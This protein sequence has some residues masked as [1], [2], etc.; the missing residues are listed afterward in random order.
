MGNT[1]FVMSCLQ[2]LR[3]PS[4]FEDNGDMIIIKGKFVLKR[5]LQVELSAR[6]I[7]N[8]E[9]ANMDGCVVLWVIARPSR[10]TVQDFVDGF[11]KYILGKLKECTVHL[12]FDR[13]IDYSTKSKTRSF[14]AGQKIRRCHT[15]TLS[16]P[17]HPQQVVLNLTVNR[18]QVIKMIFRQL[19]QW[20]SK[21]SHQIPQVFAIFC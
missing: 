1:S 20:F 17:F 21:F 11:L 9:M 6:V 8:P 5:K 2:C 16:T 18:V 19:V 13:Y 4:M 3:P 10:G 7:T 15:L 12:V 14:R